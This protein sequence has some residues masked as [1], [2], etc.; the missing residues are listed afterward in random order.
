MFD[1]DTRDELDA[2]ETCLRELR[3]LA[4][5]A[6][7]DE[8]INSE[9]VSLRMPAI[10]H[11]LAQI[12]SR[13]ANGFVW[14]H[15]LKINE[16]SQP[17]D[18]VSA[19]TARLLD[20]EDAQAR[21]ASQVLVRNMFLCRQG[22]DLGNLFVPFSKEVVAEC[23]V[24]QGT[25]PMLVPLVEITNEYE[26]VGPPTGNHGYYG[27]PP[28]SPIM[29]NLPEAPVSRESFQQFLAAEADEAFWNINVEAHKECG[30]VPFSHQMDAMPF[31]DRATELQFGGA[32]GVALC[33]AVLVKGARWIHR[34]QTDRCN[35]RPVPE[36]LLTMYLGERVVEL[37]CRLANCIESLKS[38]ARPRERSSLTFPD[39]I[40]PPSFEESAAGDPLPDFGSAPDRPAPARGLGL[41]I[42]V[43]QGSSR[44]HSRD[45][46]KSMD[47]THST[48]RDTPS[49]AS[50]NASKRPIKGTPA[51]SLI[52]TTE[53][54]TARQYSPPSDKAPPAKRAK[55]DFLAAA[56]AAEQAQRERSL[57]PEES[58]SDSDDLQILNTRP[59]ET[60]PPAPPQ[61]NGPPPIP[62]RP[63]SV[64]PPALS[65]KDAVKN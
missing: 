14:L 25:L 52:A 1:D 37:H 56:K 27:R 62:Q 51:R 32:N 3:S 64:G 7:N 42:T 15:V 5:V 43:P 22:E 58:S 65:S 40:D 29:F 12:L 48:P 44:E 6:L 36:V 31:T 26:T 28:R 18:F 61:R 54:I 63:V 33:V 11:Q 17:I 53:P 41:S 10:L 49:R 38:M 35:G 9:H 34:S 46:G 4:A 19:S 57:M 55:S 8:S 20:N 59:D 24:Y 45:T 39:F 21:A 13:G 60:A 23:K 16:Q 47:T 2:F 50:S 30:P